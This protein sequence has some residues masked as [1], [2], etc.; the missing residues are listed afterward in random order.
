MIQYLQVFCL[1]S[2]VAAVYAV[3]AE[4]VYESKG[5]DGTVEFSD[6]KSPDARKVTVQPNVLEVTPVKP[7]EPLPERTVEAVAPGPA[8]QNDIE[9]VHTGVA[10]DEL[11]R[12]ER[13]RLR[14]KTEAR[15]EATGSEKTVS[16]GE[17]GAVHQR[18][19]HHRR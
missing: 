8:G 10:D 5:K 15:R 3:G 9:V 2:L 6:H 17:S 14:E 19:R 18:A 1:L 13:R 4:E 16:G 12:R 7:L 11:D